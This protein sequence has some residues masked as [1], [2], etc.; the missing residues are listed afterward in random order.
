MTWSRQSIWVCRLS[1]QCRRQV[2]CIYGK[3]PTCING[4]SGNYTF[5]GLKPRRRPKKP[6]IPK[7]KKS[8]LSMKT[9]SKEF[10]SS[11]AHTYVD[12]G[13]FSV[14]PVEVF[15]M[16]MQH[17][18]LRDQYKVIC[19][20]NTAFFS[21]ARKLSNMDFKAD[22]CFLTRSGTQPSSAIMNTLSTIHWHN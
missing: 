14:I 11:N 19:K 6:S 10:A 12:C 21:L 20:V 15:S 1:R 8:D 2:D 4:S 22:I 16:I 3:F 18:T 5:P 17:F 13:K 9:L 7:Y